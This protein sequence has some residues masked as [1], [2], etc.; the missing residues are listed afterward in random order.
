MLATSLLA[1][2]AIAF[3]TVGA[4]ASVPGVFD[5]DRE[6]PAVYRP[7]PSG[8]VLFD[9][10]N[11][12]GPN[13]PSIATHGWTIRNGTGGPGAEGA[14]WSPNAVSFPADDSAQGKKVM[15]LRATT[16]GTAAGTSQAQI[17]TTKAKFFTGT[18]AARVYFNDEPTSGAAGNDYPLQTFYAIS[19]VDR[20]GWENERYSELDFEYLP[21]RGWGAS[22]P[23]LYATSWN[24]VGEEKLKKPKDNDF[25]NAVRSFKGWHTLQ[26]TAESSTVVYYVDGVRFHSIEGSPPG[27]PS[28]YAPGEPMTINFNQWFYDLTLGARAPGSWDQKVNWV[29]Y[30]GS[31]ALSP[32]QVNAAVDGYYTTGTH[33]IDTVAEKSP[34]PDPRKS[35]QHDYNGDGISDVSLTYDHGMTGSPSCGENASI[36][37]KTSI[38]AGKDAPSGSLGP[39]VSQQDIPCQT[40]RPKFVSSGDYNGDGKTDIAS[41]YDYGVSPACPT[42]NHVEIFVSLADPDGSGSLQAPKKVWDGGCWGPGTA[43]MDSGDFNGDGMS[44]LALLYDDTFGRVRLFTFDAPQSGVGPF[45]PL[46]WRWERPEGPGQPTVKFLTT[47]DYNGDGT[48]DVA[49][50]YDYGATQSGCT[51]AHQAIYTLTANTDRSGGFNGGGPPQRVWDSE[52]WG[53]GTAF[54]D[55]GDFNGDGM[56]DLT[57]MYDYGNE[58]V[59][60]FILDAHENGDGRF[61]AYLT[62][63]WDRTGGGP[64]VPFLTTGDYNGDG[65]SDVA[66]FYD[67]G[68]HGARPGCGGETHQAVWTLTADADGTGGLKAAKQVWDDTCWGGGTRFMN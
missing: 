20:L 48:S 22:G 61:A 56:S 17:N 14:V 53:P 37:T 60:L 47:G 38:L 1:C 13:D 49:L 25:Y 4:S 2:A 26:I 18:Y 11:Y 52:C 35:P 5:P 24:R 30:N 8:G 32:D 44:D 16:N 12:T 39:A 45:G 33:F 65:K 64:A 57:L 42:S 54:M 3:S 28:K 51:A 6:V 43:F 62:P 66:L 15:Q 9:D 41:F 50:F 10:F 40:A 29:Y 27:E 59:R 68:L 34:Q 58:R 46:T 67:Y 55:S 7:A 36:R 31:G 23:S 21:N 63:Q 19:A